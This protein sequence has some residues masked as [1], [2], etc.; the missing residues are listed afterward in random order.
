MVKYL[1]TKII[2][3][4]YHLATSDNN[5]LSNPDMEEIKREAS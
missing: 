4:D 2:I 5:W 1:E 3:N